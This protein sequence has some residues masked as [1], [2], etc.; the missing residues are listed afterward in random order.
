MLRRRN[1]RGKKKRVISG[2]KIKHQLISSLQTRLILNNILE[3]KSKM[4]KKLTAHFLV[5]TFMTIKLN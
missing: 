3:F 5:T 1:A 2:D 4:F